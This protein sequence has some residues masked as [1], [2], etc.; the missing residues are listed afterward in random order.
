VSGCRAACRYTI[1][2][3][4]YKVSALEAFAAKEERESGSL[5]SIEI[6]RLKCSARLDTRAVHVDGFLVSPPGGLRRAVLRA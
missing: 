2:G 5:Y 6:L 3:V 4:Y 1:S